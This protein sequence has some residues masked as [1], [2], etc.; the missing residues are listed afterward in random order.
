MLPLCHV[1]ASSPTAKPQQPRPGEVCLQPM[2]TARTLQEEAAALRSQVQALSAQLAARDSQLAEQAAQLAQFQSLFQQLLAGAAADA[3]AAEAP[4]CAEPEL[5]LPPGA[6]VHDGGSGADAAAA[7]PTAVLQPL[8]TAG[9]LP[10]GAAGIAPAQQAQQQQ[11]TLQQKEEQEAEA[12]AAQQPPSPLLGMSDGGQGFPALGATPH[13]TA[14]RAGSCSAPLPGQ[15]SP[16]LAAPVA[17]PAGALRPLGSSAGAVA[18]AAT[19]PPAL[20]P[21]GLATGQEAGTGPAQG[22]LME[23]AS[24]SEEEGGA[25]RCPRSAG[26]L[27]GAKCGLLGGF[28]LLLWLESKL[29]LRWGTPV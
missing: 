23:A 3:A 10:A 11:Q 29:P 22:L 15:G 12:A 8:G 19:S 18:P 17:A 26:Q 28:S 2:H 14:Q 20:T 1:P 9:P 24:V 4:G 13:S 5:A 6:M 27:P 25:G 7:V 16:N 21:G